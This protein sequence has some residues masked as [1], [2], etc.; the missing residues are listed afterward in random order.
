MK[1]EN[2]IMV[3]WG[4]PPPGRE[5]RA[6]EILRGMTDWLVSVEKAQRITG[7]QQFGFNTGPLHER[8]GFVLVEGSREQIESFFRSED[9]RDH[10]RRIALV[11]TNLQIDVLEFGAAI[12]PRLEAWD[13]AVQELRK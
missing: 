2:A 12:R 9:F 5:H 6:L 1:G 8:S 13:A 7:F 3:R 4:L 10:T 11:T